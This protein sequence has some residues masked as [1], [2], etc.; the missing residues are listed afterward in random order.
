LSYEQTKK[1]VLICP[2]YNGWFQYFKGEILTMKKLLLLLFL[3]PVIAS[4]QN[5]IE[6]YLG[7]GYKAFAT[8]PAGWRKGSS[9]VNE[10]CYWT[11]D[12][13]VGVCI[14]TKAKDG[15]TPSKLLADYISGLSTQGCEDEKQGSAENVESAWKECR[16]QVGPRTEGRIW[17]VISYKNTRNAIVV[18]V[19]I[20]DNLN[21]SLQKELIKMLDGI[22]YV[23]PSAP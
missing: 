23:D 2:Y 18:D 14:K 3:S 19:Y 22:R 7:D 9:L 11:T 17:T 4:S 10:W 20:T 13:S 5:S 16:V 12:N 15:R 6:L 1:I 8:P 21:E